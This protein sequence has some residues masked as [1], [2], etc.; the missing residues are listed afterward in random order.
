MRFE[1][2]FCMK[3]LLSC[4]I[5]ARIFG[6]NK[7]NKEKKKKVAPTLWNV[8]KLVIPWKSHSLFFVV[9]HWNWYNCAAANICMPSAGLIGSRCTVAI[10]TEAL[11]HKLVTGNVSQHS[12]QLPGGGG[13]GG[14]GC[15][16]RAA[17]C[18]D[19]AEGRGGAGCKEGQRKIALLWR[20]EQGRTSGFFFQHSY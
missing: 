4:L 1:R 20:R 14:G 16:Q 9:C 19:R 17:S 12:C 11:A 3:F 2:H 18:V 10:D 7:A 15:F 13:G 6:K 5:F 8:C